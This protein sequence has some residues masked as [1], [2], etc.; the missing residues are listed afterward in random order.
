MVHALRMY[1]VW[2]T[3]HLDVLPTADIGLLNVVPGAQALGRVAVLSL[4]QHL[5]HPGNDL[6]VYFAEMPQRG[7]P[8][9]RCLGEFGGWKGGA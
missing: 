4:V 5:S 2:L 1:Q 3:E 8:N 7:T 9:F 6:C